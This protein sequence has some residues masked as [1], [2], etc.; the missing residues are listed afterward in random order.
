MRCPKC[1]NTVSG[2]DPMVEVG[3]RP[4]INLGNKQ[5]FNTFDTRRYAC[6][7]CGCRFETAETVHRIIEEPTNPQ[8][9]AH[10]E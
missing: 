7:D 1:E 4:I 2:Y 6:T 5:H 8:A 9:V 3:G 10:E